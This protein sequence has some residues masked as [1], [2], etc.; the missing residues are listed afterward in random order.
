[1][2]KS[3]TKTTKDSKVKSSTKKKK[4]MAKKSLAT[5]NRAKKNDKKTKKQAPLKRKTLTK[6]AQSLP[7]KTSL[8]SFSAKTKAQKKKALP[9][10]EKNEV[11]SLAHYENELQKLLD[12]EKEEKHILKDMKGRVY[13]AVDNCDYPAVVEKHCR[14][15]F[16]GLF[17]T[18]QQKKQILEKDLLTKSYAFLIKE[19][20]PELFD[21]LLRDL[22]S[23]KNF[24]LAMRRISNEPANPLLD[25]SEDF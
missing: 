19:Q 22:S 10:P 18:I 25:E 9:A 23:E 16:F 15:H 3:Q 1:M 13:C 12:R 11:F 8:K 4:A 6:K 14:I 17:Q 5:K 21:Y 7:K 24:K 2:L 20:T